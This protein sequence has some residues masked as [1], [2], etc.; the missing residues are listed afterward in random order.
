MPRTRPFRPIETAPQDG[1][2]VEV[3]HGPEQAVVRAYWAGQ[4]QAFVREDD[5]HSKTLHGVTGWRPVSRAAP[6]NRGAQKYR[7]TR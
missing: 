5:P 3:R 2:V 6:G 7:P 1:S 4:N